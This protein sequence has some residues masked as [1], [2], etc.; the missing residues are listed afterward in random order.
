ME[1]AGVEL[2]NPS[3]CQ[4]LGRIRVAQTRHNRSN[5]Q[6]EVQIRYSSTVGSMANQRRC[7]SVVLGLRLAVSRT[8]LVC[9]LST[10]FRG[11]SRRYDLFL[12]RHGWKAEW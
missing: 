11:S 7:R 5:C 10:A 4:H 8:G 9:G 3:F 2:R 6:L 12:V 1:A